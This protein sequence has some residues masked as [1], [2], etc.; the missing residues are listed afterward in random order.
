MLFVLSRFQPSICFRYLL[1]YRGVVWGSDWRGGIWRFLFMPMLTLWVMGIWLRWSDWWGVIVWYYVLWIMGCDCGGVIICDEHCFMFFGVEWMLL[2]CY[3][4]SV[5]LW[6]LFCCSCSLRR[7]VTFACGWD[8]V[9]VSWFM[10][11]G[12]SY[13]W[14][15]VTCCVLEMIVG[16][17]SMCVGNDCWLWV[18]SYS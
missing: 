1:L 9:D 15:V 13:V 16:C 17:E 5:D 8:S 2:C 11:I 4:L 3:F 7:I 10:G 14:F 12:V 6:L 18:V